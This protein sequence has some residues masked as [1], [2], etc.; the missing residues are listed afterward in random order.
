MCFLFAAGAGAV[1]LGFDAHLQ[2]GLAPVVC[3][4]FVCRTVS[5]RWGLS[6]STKPLTCVGQSMAIEMERKY[7]PPGDE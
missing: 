1:G 6:A 3:A 4:F 5:A 7:L 2:N